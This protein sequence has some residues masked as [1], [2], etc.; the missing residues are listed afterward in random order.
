MPAV[1]RAVKIFAYVLGS[2][3]ILAVAGVVVLLSIDW[4]ALRPAI[5]E[6]ASS[7]SGR[8]VAIRGDLDVNL[9]W[10]PEIVANDVVFANAEWGSRPQMGRIEHVYMRL[11]LTPLLSG[12]VEFDRLRLVK[13]DI[14]LETDGRRRNW[15]FG[16]AKA[17]A[18]EDRGTFPVLR[19]LV[20]E[21]G[22]FSY[23][24][25]NLQ[26]AVDIQF[27]S[28]R[29]TTPDDDA[30]VQVTARGRYRK[31]GFSL[32]ATLGS[33]QHLRDQSKIY[34]VKLKARIGSTTFEA[35]GG[36]AAPID[37]DGV[38]GR[39]ELKGRN[40]SELHE[41]LGLPLPEV[42]P[43]TLAGRIRKSGNAIGVEQFEGRLG[44]SALNG[45]IKVEI[46]DKGRPRVVA[47]LTSTALHI[48]D[49]EAFWKGDD[50]RRAQ[51]GRGSEKAEPVLSR[52]AI[53]LPKLR[54]MDAAVR[55]RGKAISHGPLELENVSL[56]LRLDDGLLKLEPLELGLADGRIAA[57]LTLD[58]RQDVPAMAG[59][60]DFDGVS[61]NALMTAFGTERESD[62]LL[63][64]N[65]FVKMQGKSPHDLAA[66]ADGDGLLVMSGGR[67]RNLLLE[68][69][70]LDLQ[71]A[72][73]QWLSDDRTMVPIECLVLP[74]PVR[75][76]RL[77]TE[78]V[79]D[80]TDALVNIRGVVD[81]NTEMVQLRLEPH[82]KDFSLFNTLTA[83]DIRGDL[84]RRQADTNRVEAVGKLVLKAL[85]A[86]LMP[87]LSKS[88]EESS[89]AMSP[90]ASL[91][92]Q[93][94]RA[95]DPKDNPAAKDRNEPPKKSGP[96][97]PAPEGGGGARR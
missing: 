69:V 34:P 60:V 49:F 70:A 52:E 72:M 84:A 45:S 42:G 27:A 66:S 26:E 16:A 48:E 6:R 82:P 89:K 65:L 95:A 2:I 51:H 35:D 12:R 8:E 55:F 40:L 76:G 18:P 38:D 31:D 36:I 30:G 83:I 33:F 1:K 97:P 94:K 54:R 17:A 62:G 81:L 22:R 21:D 47:D 92:A 44:K 58:G 80:T 63:R 68:A 64:G 32:E 67:I 28:L 13:P 46:P 74:M 79:L 85:A 10:R 5:N 11:R 19:E 14:Q 88:I 50:Q 57:G 59:R 41:I 91:F 73:G 96:T 56:T 93:I 20:I 77:R 78:G 23:K 4:N 39:F 3:G 53:A 87:M 43:F 90:C 29:L 71:E 61:L 24:A 37:F 75:D 15:Q 7:A 25:P 9:S 86:P